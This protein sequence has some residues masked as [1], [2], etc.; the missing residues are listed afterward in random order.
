MQKS[1]TMVGVKDLRENLED[2]IKKINSGASFTVI[3]R[4]KPVFKISP[5]D[6]GGD[7]EE[8]VDFTKIKKGGVK[9]EEIL[10]R[11]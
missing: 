5:V 11:L 1:K 6:E 4:S 7:W 10:S 8:V 3:R 9:I 2:Y